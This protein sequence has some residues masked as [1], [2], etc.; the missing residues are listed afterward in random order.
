MGFVLPQNKTVE[1]ENICHDPEQGFEVRGADIL[2]YIDEA[3]GTWHTHPDIKSAASDADKRT[4]LNFPDW[5][6]YIV[7]T[8]GISRYVVR[9]GVVVLD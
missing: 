3:V 9:D 7:G 2:A 6:H 4:F 1:V 5:D 8:D